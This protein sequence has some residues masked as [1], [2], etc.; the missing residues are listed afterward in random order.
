MREPIRHLLLI[1]FT[2]VLSNSARSE[3]GHSSIPPSQS[4]NI[5]LIYFDDLGYG[6]IGVFGASGFTTPRLDA[7]ASGGVKL[8][9]LYASASVCTPSRAS[10]LTGLYPNRIGLEGVV[11]PNSTK[12]LSPDTTTLADVLSD[13][14]YATAAIGKWHL[15]HLPEYSPLRN[16]F[17]SFYGI[18][19]SNDMAPYVFLRDEAVIEEPYQQHS[20]TRRLTDEAIKVSSETNDTPF[21]IYLAHPMPHKPLAASEQFIGSSDAGLY[22]DVMQEMDYEIGRLIDHLRDIGELDNTIIVITSDNGPWQPWDVVDHSIGG[23]AGPFRGQ[24]ANSYEGG[25]R[26]PGIV[27]WEDQ[28]SAGQS[29]P[30]L[31]TQMDFYPTLLRWAGIADESIPDSDG[32]DMNDYLRGEMTKSPRDNFYYYHYGKL[33][34]VR[35]KEWKLLFSRQNR[36]DHWHAYKDDPAKAEL[37]FGPPLEWT[38]ER[39][40]NMH[41]NPDEMTDL[42]AE[43]PEVVAM[44]KELAEE[45]RVDLGDKMQ[46]K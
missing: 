7:L 15:G 16:G 11:G 19:Y 34:G 6:D 32:I 12:G 24:K 31:M 43:K 1:F 39:L 26:V 27:Y 44:M 9:S 42:Y 25:F 22:G 36:D 18:P 29:L 40:V 4:P 13:N 2:L 8:T 33:F 10:L 5:L 21:F 35:N 14:G 17:D 20:L 45:A 38:P 28:L 23:S 41:S 37:L 46:Q 30:D 3:T